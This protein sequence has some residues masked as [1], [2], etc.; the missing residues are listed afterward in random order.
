MGRFELRHG[1][2]PVVSVTN[3]ARKQ[4]L[5]FGAREP[6]LQYGKYSRRDR[7]ITNGPV[8]LPFPDMNVGCGRLDTHV[9]AAK[10]KDLT[11]PQA[12]LDHDNGHVLENRCRF[13]NIC[14][15]LFEGERSFSSF[16]M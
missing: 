4:I 8:G 2:S 6:A 10:L 11:G 5:A 1:A 3:P 14:S 15:F 12:H 7:N 9:L 13:L 16:F